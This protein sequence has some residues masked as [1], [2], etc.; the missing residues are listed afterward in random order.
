MFVKP[1][2][3]QHRSPQNTPGRRAPRPAGFAVGGSDPSFPVDT[4]DDSM[5]AELRK[6]HDRFRYHSAKNS[7][8][9]INYSNDDAPPPSYHDVVQ[10]R[11]TTEGAE[12]KVISTHKIKSRRHIS[13]DVADGTPTRL[14]LR[15]RRQ[16]ITQSDASVYSS[17]GSS[18]RQN[19][20]NKENLNLEGKE[21]PFIDDTPNGGSQHRPHRIHSDQ[22]AV[23]LRQ[24]KV[25]KS[26]MTMREHRNSY[27]TAVNASK[28]EYRESKYTGSLESIGG[29][30]ETP[31]LEPA[32]STTQP[33]DRAGSVDSV[34]TNKVIEHVVDR[35]IE[36]GILDCVILT[37]LVV[38][39]TLNLVGRNRKI[40]ILRRRM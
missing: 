28:T 14:N 29:S 25:S 30:S 40:V 12:R 9:K 38:A 34:L 7:T 4:S 8:N 20:H 17:E 3:R 33:L 13:P 35:Y 27:I 18:P 31:T 39:E 10:Q 1:K 21:I 6:F 5:D 19:Y 2:L 24:H 26:K 23:R 16:R 15:S 22:T 11:T 36:Y 32:T 37:Y